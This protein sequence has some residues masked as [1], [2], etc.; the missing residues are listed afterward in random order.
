MRG[1]NTDTSFL[2]SFTPNCRVCCPRYVG[3]TRSYGVMSIAPSSSTDGPCT[4]QHRFP[5]K[6]SHFLHIHSPRH[7][8]YHSYS[9]KI[10]PFETV[11]NLT[12]IT[13]G[14]GLPTKSTIRPK[15]LL[16]IH[17]LRTPKSTITK[18]QQPP[19][20]FTSDPT[21]LR[22]PNNVRCLAPLPPLLDVRIRNH[23]PASSAA[24][25]RAF[26]QLRL[27]PPPPTSV[28]LQL[29]QWVTEV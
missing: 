19:H 10:F 8:L 12:S 16:K 29:I 5:R 11:E 27:L 4:S 20:T 18:N 3:A 26:F 24:S 14:F 9:S 15:P 28:T 6:P 1:C 21:S 23:L 22:I 7:P 13:A 17:H 2:E 25:Q